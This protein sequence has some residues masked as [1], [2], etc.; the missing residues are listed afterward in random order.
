MKQNVKR[1]C[2]EVYTVLYKYGGGPLLP[3]YTEGMG[4]GGHNIPFLPR[5][6]AAAAAVAQLA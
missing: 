2:G 4:M 5:P 6:A 3:L 1:V